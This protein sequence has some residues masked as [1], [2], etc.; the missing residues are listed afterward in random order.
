MKRSWGMFRALDLESTPTNE[1]SSKGLRAIMSSGLHPPALPMSEH[2]WSYTVAAS[3]YLGG[4]PHS[5]YASLQPFYPALHMHFP[6][7]SPRDLQQ[8]CCDSMSAQVEQL[9]ESCHRQNWVWP[10]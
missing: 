3:A 8:S 5:V 2:N 10:T 4:C 9:Q 1:K 6:E 7:S